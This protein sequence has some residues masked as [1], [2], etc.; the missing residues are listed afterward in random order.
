[1]A[2]TIDEKS[3]EP[4]VQRRTHPDVRRA[5]IL[6]RRI[7]LVEIFASRRRRELKIESNEDAM[8]RLVITNRTLKSRTAP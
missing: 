8:L 6:I 3:T 2:K 5:L 1:M 7:T 4:N